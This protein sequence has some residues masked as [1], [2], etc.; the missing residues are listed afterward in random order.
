M[1]IIK[2]L[3][4]TFSITYIIGSSGIVIDLSKFIYN[5]TH[6][7]EWNYQIIV[8]PF[9]CSVCMT[10]WVILIYT[11]ISGLCIIYS[12]GIACTMAIASILIDKL[13]KKI[14]G[15]FNSVN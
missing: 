7:K 4:I 2:I 14:I 3:I 5:L 6:K 11:L 15:I 1:L 8:K 10:F 13:I 9:S 12:L